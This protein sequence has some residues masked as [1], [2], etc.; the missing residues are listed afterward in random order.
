MNVLLL[1]TV[2]KNFLMPQILNRAPSNKE[3]NQ[4]SP[5]MEVGLTEKIMEF[6]EFFDYRRSAH[7]FALDEVEKEMF[8][9]TW[10]YARRKV[11]AYAG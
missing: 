10:K 4:R 8:Y 6:A 2:N 11:R 1:K 3:R 7:Q 9:D 5:A